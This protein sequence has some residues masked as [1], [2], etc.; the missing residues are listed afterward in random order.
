MLR[1][2][3]IGQVGKEVNHSQMQIITE[4]RLAI[5][6]GLDQMEIQFSEIKMVDL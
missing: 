5:L 3:Q 1:I 2:Y 4:D 6:L